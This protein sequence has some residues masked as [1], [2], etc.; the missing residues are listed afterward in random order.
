MCLNV[1]GYVYTPCLRRHTSRSLRAS[2]P[3]LPLPHAL[4][5]PPAPAAAVLPTLPDI[6][7]IFS[8]VPT[9]DSSL[10]RARLRY[11][12][13]CATA[14]C[15]T[16]PLPLP[17]STYHLSLAFCRAPR[18]VFWPDAA[19]HAR[20]PHT[21]RTAMGCAAR[22]TRTCTLRRTL[23]TT[24]YCAAIRCAYAPHL[25]VRTRNAALVT[26]IFDAATRRVCRRA[27]HNIHHRMVTARALPAHA[28]CSLPVYVWFLDCQFCM[29]AA[30]LR[31]AL[32]RRATCCPYL[33]ALPLPHDGS[34][35]IAYL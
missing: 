21:R 26:R 30:L 13:S 2:R 18:T 22:V 20:L 27:Y 5:W 6:Y 35:R 4:C 33:R 28:F 8:S 32:I 29:R 7:W 34:C 25:R 3:P 19:P 10:P 24:P 15:L 11:L 1:N 12:P 17:F 16:M 9:L 14:F 23:W 31:S